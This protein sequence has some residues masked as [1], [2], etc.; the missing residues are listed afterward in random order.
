MTYE[1]SIDPAEYHLGPGDVFE[2]R[3]WTSGE[4]SYPSVSLDNILL[5]PNLGAF[6]VRGETLAQVR[7]DVMQ[8]AGESFASRKQDPNHPPV[9]LALYQPRKIYV[10]VQGDVITPGVYALSASSRAD[11]AVDV[12]N[13]VDPSLQPSREPGTQKQMEIDQMGK[14]RLES[15]FGERE[16]EPASKRYIT[17]THEDGTIDRIDLVRY[18]SMHDPK[19]CPPSA[20]ET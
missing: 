1:S 2:C 3:F 19:A 15:F 20:R 5:I 17:V 10:T 14:K 9:T 7:Q 6:D 18:N 16:P 11:V 12:A 4:T 13:K 8:K